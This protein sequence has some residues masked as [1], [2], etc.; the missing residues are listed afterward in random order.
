MA[1]F[2]VELVP[3]EIASFVDGW[4]GRVVEGRFPLLER[5]SG[6]ENCGSYFTVLQGMHE[7]VIHLISTNSAEADAATVQWQFAMSLSH[8]HLERILAEGRSVIDGKEVVYVVCERSSTNLAK[9]IESGA[10]APDRARKIFGPIVDAVLYLHSNGIIHGHLNP[11]SIHFD[12]ANPKLAIN[13]LLI[14]AS[15]KR[16]ISAP[17]NYDAPE[18]WQGEA[19]AAADTWSLGMT[20]WEAM[21][22]TPPSW[23]LWRDEEPDVPAS[24]PSPFRDI[25]RESLHLDPGR[26]CT[27]ESIQERLSIS[28]AMPVAD[29][30]IQPGTDKHVR[31]QP[32]VEN[33]LPAVAPVAA[34]EAAR[35]E[36]AAPR[37]SAPEEVEAEASPE[38]VLF[39]GAL[40][41]F[42]DAHLPRSRVVPYAV[43]LL[44]VIAIGTFLF[45]REHK[46]GASSTATENAPTSSTPAPQGQAASSPAPPPATE[47]TQ[48][49]QAPPA[50][51]PTESQEQAKDVPQAQRSGTEPSEAQPAAVQ[52]A[53][54]SQAEQTETQTATAANPPVSK[55]PSSMDRERARENGK[56]L[57]EKRVMPTVSPG[58]RGGMRRPVEVLI[59]VSVNQA[60]SVSDASY[61][62]PGPGNYFARAAQRAALSWKFKPPVQ[63]GG[64]ER[65]VWM[66]R[67][68][69]GRA[70]TE[71]TATEQE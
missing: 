59:R 45:V 8:P 62:V 24:L 38:P 61:V 55:A 22:G 12:G 41:H 31:V 7:A 19:S 35:V 5:L 2:S 56:G 30:S 36:K 58:A 71:A 40:T 54:A 17:G 20:M 9:T 18:L 70:G 57:V 53:Q 68:N 14:A 11:A 37:F 49:A 4:E 44:A 10:L 66:L 69:F 16:R 34:S 48:P 13:E 29:G 28:N 52:P 42:E 50:T 6:N 51:S 26:R 64:R 65:S 33:T 3:M 63:N 23:D 1:V 60:G 15:G 21:A 27:L 39:S 32:G 46:A 25:V 67:F 43:V 47:S